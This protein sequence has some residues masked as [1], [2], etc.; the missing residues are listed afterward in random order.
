MRLVVFS[1]KRCWRSP[2]G[3]VTTDGGFAFQMKAIAELFDETL[4]VVPCMSSAANA[5]AASLHGH[6][7]S[8]VPLSPLAGEDWHRKLAFPWW[9]LRNAPS[10][11]TAI[12]QADA[13]HTPIPGDI[14]TLGMVLAWLWRKPLFVRHCGN[15]LK[16][17]TIAERFVKWFME[18][19]AGGRNV[20]LATGGALEPP[21]RRNPAN[22]WIF[23]TA[24]TEEELTRLDR[25]RGPLAPGRARLIIACRQVREKGTGLVVESLPWLLESF[26]RA[27]LD[28]VGDGDDLAAFKDLAFKLKVDGCVTFHGNVA[29]TTLLALL[30]DADLFCYPTSASEGFP[31]VVLEA[32]ACGLPV[33]TTRVSVLPHLI[34]TGCGQILNGVAPDAIALAVKSCLSSPERYRAMSRQATITARQYSLERWRDAIGARLAS[35]WGPLQSHA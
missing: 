33:V 17:V 26:P 8:V 14:G 34:G 25:E 22:D 5:G 6:G 23:S 10:L 3:L 11:W 4:V 12:K 35:A 27:H 18:R 7:L 24:L 20:M 29:H 31:K 1:H 19:Y 28:V 15:W 32:L 16:Q 30:Q 2:D 13:V 9:L 21:S